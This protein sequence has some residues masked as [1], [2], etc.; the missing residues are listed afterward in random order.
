M[1]SL[2]LIEPRIEL[3]NAAHI[4]LTFEQK[5]FGEANQRVCYYSFFIL[6]TH[7][8]K[9]LSLTPTFYYSRPITI[10]NAL[11]NFPKFRI[12]EPSKLL[13]CRVG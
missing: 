11:I 3:Q 2:R 5:T 10:G 8:L 4:A 13:L 1:S 9:T 12:L 7:V 6:H